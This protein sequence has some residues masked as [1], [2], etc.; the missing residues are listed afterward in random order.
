MIG[1]TIEK[2]EVLEK[3]GEGGMAVVYLARHTTLGRKVAIKVLHPHLASSAKNRTR[4]EREAH[5]I[6]SLRHP[7]ILRIFDYSGPDSER[8]FIV[9]E[10]IEG[11]TLREVLDQVG[12]IMAEPAALIA[13]ELCDAMQ[14]AHNKGI[15][16]RDLKPENVML[17]EQGTVK[18]MDFGIARIVDDSHVTMTGALVG[19]P[20]Y[21]SPEQATDTEVDHRSDLFALGIVLYRMV[22]GALPFRGGNP[23]VVL[24]AIIDGNFQSPTER[25]PSLSPAVTS[26]ILRCLST[27]REARY[28]SASEVR[29]ALDKFLRSVDINP[30]EPGGWKIENYL[31]NAEQYEQRLL[32]HLMVVLV[33]RGKGEVAR[34]DTA[35][36]LRTFHRVLALDGDNREV[37]NIIEGMRPPSRSEHRP[38]G[39]KM[40]WWTLATVLIVTFAVLGITSDGFKHW[41]GD[42]E[43]LVRIA[44]VPM[45]AIP[46]AERAPV[47]K[48]P[49][50]DAPDPTAEPGADT[51]AALRQPNNKAGAKRTS[52]RPA[53][54]VSAVKAADPVNAPERRPTTSGTTATAPPDGTPTNAAPQAAIPAGTGQLRVITVNGA[55]QVF[56]DGRYIDWTPMNAIS[57]PSGRHQLM[58]PE[59]AYHFAHA[60]EITVLPDQDN[61]KTVILKYKPARVRFEGFP[62]EATLDMNGQDMG[63]LG[64]KRDVMLNERGEFHFTLASGTTVIKRVSITCGV[65]SKDLMPGTSR[66]IRP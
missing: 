20:A 5:A 32:E 1:E 43:P 8:C 33:E 10:Y 31:T 48:R 64:T 18:L 49:K 26:I 44:P 62:A 30:E 40:L 3:I 28:D 21:M 36:A 57:L 2:F 13:R 7:N 39:S 34:K 66:V 52:R 47:V 45:L 23:S 22:T 11:P 65:E 24:K 54:V 63:V 4:F 61:D 46:I 50:A 59:T 56:I 42:L 55:G 60:E 19:S 51:A 27:D 38:T 9:T 25:V 14:T 37:I 41:D 53:K 17:N 12:V 16:H 6:E 29:A 58:V 35:A 15:V